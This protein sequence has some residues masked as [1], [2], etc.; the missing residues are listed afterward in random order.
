MLETLDAES[1][2]RAG[3]VESAAGKWGVIC[4][5]LEVAAQLLGVDAVLSVKHRPEGAAERDTREADEADL[6]GADA[7]AAA[8]RGRGDNYSQWVHH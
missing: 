8:R 2:C 6:I 1:I 3:V 4:V 7:A 5:A